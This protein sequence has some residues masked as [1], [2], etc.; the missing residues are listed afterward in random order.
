MA[1][2]INQVIETREGFSVPSGTYVRF[3]TIFPASKLEV[4]YNMEFYRNE[5]SFDDGESN[6]FPTELS[7]LGYVDT[8]AQHLYTGL[9]PTVVNLNLKTYLETI[10]TGGTIDIIL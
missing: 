5:T 2:R 4:H 10:Y 6:Y 1:L 8:V 9:T 3:N 7:T